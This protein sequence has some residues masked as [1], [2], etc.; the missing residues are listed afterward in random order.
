MDSG[1][2]VRRHPKCREVDKVVSV[3]HPDR[4]ASFPQNK[5]VLPHLNTR[6]LVDGSAA[7]RPAAQERGVCMDI[8]HMPQGTNQKRYLVLSRDDFS[9]WK[10][11]H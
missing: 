2:E 11:D 9:G 8:V 1:R 6:F 4:G 3:Q 10:A 7:L 5:H